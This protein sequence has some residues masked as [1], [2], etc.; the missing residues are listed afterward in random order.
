[1]DVEELEL[2]ECD[3]PDHRHTIDLLYRSYRMNNAI[4]D[5]Q[6]QYPDEEEN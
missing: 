2:L 1:M 3:D 5:E 6:Y 4:D